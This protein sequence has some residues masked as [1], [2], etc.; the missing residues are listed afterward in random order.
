M[1]FITPAPVCLGQGAGVEGGPPA[2]GAS[3]YK[4]M[5]ERHARCTGPLPRIDQVGRSGITHLWPPRYL[6]AILGALRSVK[7]ELSD[8]VFFVGLSTGLLLIPCLYY[9][10]KAELRG[11]SLQSQG[12]S[13]GRT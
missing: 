10:S 1:C 4:T 8:K 13:S 9:A 7:R 3:I 2:A 5:A 12:E 6:Q 11:E